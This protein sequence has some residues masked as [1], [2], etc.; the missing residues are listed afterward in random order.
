[1]QENDIAF[2]LIQYIVDNELTIGSKLPSIRELAV[3][4]NCN[5][6]QVRTGLISLSALGVIDMHSRAG[7]FVKQLAPSDLDTL[8]VL[9]FQL[10][11]LGK[12]ADTVNIYA[13]KALLDKETFKNA[14]KYRTEND[15]I[16]LEDNLVHQAQ[17]FE[18]CKAFVDADEEFHLIIAQISRNPLI[19]FLL[20]A[21]QVMLRPYRHKNLTPDVCKESYKSHEAIFEAI[22]AKNEADAERV[23]I[24]HTSTRIQ[25]LRDR[26]E[27]QPQDGKA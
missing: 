3:L 13:V 1:M 7:S 6:S 21:I 14:I 5:Q 19:V 11:M 15:L 10:G 23:A 12:E 4:W 17:V 27:A 24:L 25:R 8:F 2:K 20:E 9:F 18:D 16:Q 22:K 26:K